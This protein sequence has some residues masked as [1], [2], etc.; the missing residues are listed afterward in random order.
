MKKEK[1]EKV[2]RRFFKNMKL[3]PRML[4]ALAALSVALVVAVT[5]AVAVIYRNRMEHEYS[6]SAFQTATIAANL[7]DGDSIARYRQTGVKDEYSETTRQNLQMIRK[8]TG[9]KYLYV[10]IPEDVQ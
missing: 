8:T 4:A 10:V 3:Q 9:A 5:L 1:K 7:I 2:T 6:T